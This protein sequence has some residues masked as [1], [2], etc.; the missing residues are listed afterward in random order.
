L[1]EVPDAGVEVE[2][3]V[4]R[5]SSFEIKINDVLVYSKLKT[6][7]FPNNQKVSQFN[8]TIKMILLL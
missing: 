4:G 6:G 5:Q 2:G 7:S 3:E 1:K 8:L